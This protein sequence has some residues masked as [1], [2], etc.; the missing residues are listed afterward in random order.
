MIDNVKE[1][2]YFAYFR[3]MKHGTEVTRISCNNFKPSQGITV[4]FASTVYNLPPDADLFYGYPGL[5]EALE[6]AKDGAQAY[7]EMLIGEGDDALPVL[8]Q[9][10][11]DHYEDLGVN[12]VESNIRKL[13]AVL[14]LNPDFKWI[15]YRIG[16]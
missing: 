14:K 1:Q 11:M 16:R 8:L 7:I 5:I 9:Y 6:K 12:L 2:P 4:N 15:P 13:E 10:R 3:V